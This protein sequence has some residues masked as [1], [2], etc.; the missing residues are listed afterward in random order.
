[1]FAGIGR[2]R[3]LSGG[4]NFEGSPF[5]MSPGQF[6]V[7]PTEQAPLPPSNPGPGTSLPDADNH[8]HL[9]L[10]PLRS[11]FAKFQATSPPNGD[12]NATSTQFA[13][14]PGSLLSAFL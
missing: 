12:S 14:P 1:M 7:M 6:A 2:V 11:C 3:K 9:R 8:F 13:Q 5:S 10:R 4:L